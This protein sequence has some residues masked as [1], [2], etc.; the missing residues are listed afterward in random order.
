MVQDRKIAKMDMK[1][2]SYKEMIQYLQKEKV[3][4]ERTFESKIK[5]MEEVVAHDTEEDESQH[6][7]EPSDR[8]IIEKD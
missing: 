7:S 1:I 5:T 8:D 4:M 3:E 6:R 2:K